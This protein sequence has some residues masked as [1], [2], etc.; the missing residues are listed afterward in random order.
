MVETDED[1]R[2]GGGRAEKETGMGFYYVGKK[3]PKAAKQDDR[4]HFIF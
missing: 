1:Q 4:V 2:S 3:K